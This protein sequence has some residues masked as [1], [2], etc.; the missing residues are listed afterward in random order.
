MHDHARFAELR[1]EC[2]STLSRFVSLR[3]HCWAHIRIVRKA[4]NVI[5]RGSPSR[6]GQ[7]VIGIELDRLIKCRQRFAIIGF[8]VPRLQVSMQAAEV[9]IVGIG[10]LRAA[11]PN[12]ATLIPTA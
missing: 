8:P 4:I 12:F 6:I 10:V 1:R 5:E 7:R 11:E 9:G 3:E 2:Q